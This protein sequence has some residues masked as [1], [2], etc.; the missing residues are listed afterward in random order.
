MLVGVIVVV[1]GVMLVPAQRADSDPGPQEVV[2]YVV[3]P[4]DTLWSYAEE[5]T[6]PGGDVNDTI[7]ELKAMNHMRTSSLRV[8]DRIVVPKHASQIPR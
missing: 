2:S 6:P 5:I 4:G 1:G 8:G 7:D 3:A